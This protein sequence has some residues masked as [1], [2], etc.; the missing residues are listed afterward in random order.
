MSYKLKPKVIP[1]YKLPIGNPNMPRA[2]PV[3]AN[4][5]TPLPHPKWAPKN[6]PLWPRL[7]K[8]VPYLGGALLAYE[9]YELY[10]EWNRPMREVP[11]PNGKLK[12]NETD[13]WRWYGPGNTWSSPEGDEMSAG[14]YRQLVVLSPPY[15]PP[16]PHE[17]PLGNTMAVTFWNQQPNGVW[18]NHSSYFYDDYKTFPLKPYPLKPIPLPYNE[19]MYE[20]EPYLIPTTVPMGVPSIAPWQLPHEWP[21]NAPSPDPNSVPRSPNVPRQPDPLPR[22]FP[23]VRPDYPVWPFP[24]PNPLP[25]PK[26]NPKPKPEPF[27]Q[28]KPGENPGTNPNPE[29]VPIS[30]PGPIPVSPP[31]AHI[32]PS[33]PALE[34]EIKPEG[35]LHPYSSPHELRK[36]YSH[37]KERKKRLPQEAIYQ[38]GLGM[39]RKFGK[40]TEADDW[41]KAVYK[42]LPWR[43]R[44]WRGRDGIWRDR[45]ANTITRLSRIYEYAH[46]INVSEAIKN[47]M[48]DNAID[49]AGGKFGKS[50]AKA[51]AKNGVGLTGPQTGEKMKQQI[52]DDAAKKWKRSQPVP[53]RTYRQWEKVDQNKLYTDPNGDIRSYT[54]RRWR[55]T[56]RV[57][58]N[59]QIPWYQYQTDK[60]KRYQNPNKAY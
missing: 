47:I 17:H 8:F 39:M 45:D 51:T 11:N 40:F 1:P 43:I 15:N 31:G 42:A 54:G 38:L 14:L 12:V 10:R 3:G 55:L 5:N 25:H 58:P 53:Q 50:L 26:P 6:A 30:E 28:P 23:E 33:L 16:E 41:A 18:V 49:K 34:T 19:P 29:E 13:G 27:P 4:T 7:G 46:D 59:T 35:S 37:E 36:P 32:P 48:V 21:V 60:G 44:R 52:W 56:D 24:T 57:R 9:A 20:P 22:P 2:I